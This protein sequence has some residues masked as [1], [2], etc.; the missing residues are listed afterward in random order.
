MNSAE[1]RIVSHK[2][3]WKEAAK[4]WQNMIIERILLSNYFKM[5]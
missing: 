2:E 3:K 1:D 5:I 4:Y